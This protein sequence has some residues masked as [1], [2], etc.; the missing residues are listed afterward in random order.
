MKCTERF[1]IAA[2]ATFLAA[3]LIAPGAAQQIADPGFKSVG[4]GAPLAVAMPAPTLPL[5][6]QAANATPEQMQRV[7]QEL[8]QYPF[9]GPMNLGAPGG[10]QGAPPG[11]KIG[12]AF[13]GAVPSGVQALPV[14]IFTSKDFYQDRALWTDKRYFRCNSPQGLEAQR[15]AIFPA[16]IGNDPPRTAAWGYCDRD[17]PR[18]AHREPVQVQDRAGALRG[19]ARGNQEARRTYA[20]HLCHRA[21]RAERPLCAGQ[22]IRELVFDD[23]RRCSS[24]PCCRC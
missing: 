19:A 20:A 15:G 17:Y 14:D 3:S 5:G 6:P 2:A 21:G 18:K 13:D 11:V 24:R 22:P 7:F 16:T 10:Q 4:R 8:M 23:D 1:W 9:V 12:A